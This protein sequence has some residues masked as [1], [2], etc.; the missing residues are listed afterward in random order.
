MIT[1]GKV[2]VCEIDGFTYRGKV[3]NMKIDSCSMSSLFLAF[4]RIGSDSALRF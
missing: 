3:D 4:L 1:I 2:L